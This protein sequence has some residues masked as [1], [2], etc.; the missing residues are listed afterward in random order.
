MQLGREGLFRRGK[1]RFKSRKP[2]L[3]GSFPIELRKGK[4]AEDEGVE[5]VPGRPVVEPE[6]RQRV[7]GTDIQG[8]QNFMAACSEKAVPRLAFFSAS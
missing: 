2:G 1:S 4:Q 3:N 7:D 6:I 8:Y 5:K